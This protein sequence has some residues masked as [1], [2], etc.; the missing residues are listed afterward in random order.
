MKY[1]IFFLAFILISFNLRSQDITV[2]SLPENSMAYTDFET[3]EI[4]YSE[5][6]KIYYSNGITDFIELN[7]VKKA[8]GFK[9]EMEV[10]G[11]TLHCTFPDDESIYKINLRSTVM[12]GHVS[13]ISKGPD[14]KEQDFISV[15]N[16]KEPK[17]EKLLKV[18]YQGT[19]SV[20]QTMKN[21]QV[22]EN[23]K[24]R[25]KLALN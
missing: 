25:I 9:T 6:N 13:L 4:I 3:G 14:N 2:N 20:I 21:N 22:M 23:S 12:M 11:T 7:I 18:Y 15:G 17:F 1:Y 16:I 10:N 24:E 5:N 8:S 19:Y